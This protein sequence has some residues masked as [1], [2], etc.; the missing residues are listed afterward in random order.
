MDPIL[1]ATLDLGQSVWLD[2]IS[3]ELMDSG[4][5]HKLITDGLRGMTSNPTIFQQAISKGSDYDRDIEQGLDREEQ[6]AAIFEHIAVKDVQR[7]CDI[8]RPVYDQS[9]GADGFVS[10]EVSPGTAYD[11]A[12]TID[13]ALR[14]W[15][16]VH[17]PNVMVKVPGTDAGMPAIKALLAEGLNINITLLFSLAQY[18]QVTEMHLQAVEERIAKGAAVNRIASVASFFVSRVDNVADKLLEEKGRKPLR[19]TA[20][21]ANA[22]M[23]YKHFLNVTGS[24][25]WRKLSAQGVRVQ[26]PLWASTSTK[27]PE[28]S[29]ILY[30]QELIA[31]HTINTMPPQTLEAFR[32]HGQPQKSLLRNLETAEQ[33]LSQIAAAGVD[34]DKVTHDLID[35][36]VKKF[37]ESY[38]NV[39]AAIET[40]SRAKAQSRQRA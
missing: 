13:E 2:F 10:I 40:K 15:N 34:L 9:D 4:H 1:K 27:N 5:L 35:D 22:C 7:A 30:V 19:G 29:D 36:G 20:A 26:R 24:E 12:R 39:L 32:D 6:P 17:R 31:A 21:I 37:G 11:T 14:L 16:S 23:A 33:T 8:I 38:D 18:R 28:Y 3:R 25:R